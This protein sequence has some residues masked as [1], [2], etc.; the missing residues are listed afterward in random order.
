MWDCY[1]DRFKLQEV[2]DNFQM[3]QGGSVTSVNGKVGAVVL[4]AEDVGALP[5]T[6]EA[7]VTSVNTKTGDVVLDAGDIAYESSTV[8]VEL[9]TI[10]SALS[11]LQSVTEIIDTASGAIASFPDGSGLP[12]RSLVAQI[13]PVQDLHGQS[14]PYPAGGGKNKFSYANI[15][16]KNIYRAN[17]QQMGTDPNAFYLAGAAGT[18]DNMQ[19]S[20]SSWAYVC[21]WIGYQTTA[22]TTLTV[23]C[24][25]KNYS[26][27][28]NGYIRIRYGD[29]QARESSTAAVTTFFNDVGQYQ[30]TATATIPSGKY[31]GL[32]F[33]PAAK[34]SEFT[35]T[36]YT[37]VT[38]YQLEI[39][40]T[41]TTFAP[42]SN[43]C[44]ISGHTGLSV[45]VR[46]KNLANFVNGK[47]IATTGAV[48][49]N[50]K[51]IATVDPISVVSGKSY[52]FSFRG[53]RPVVGAYAVWAGETLVRR[54]INIASGTVLNT[55]D[56]DRFYVSVYDAAETSS[57]VA[58]TVEEAQGQV[59][60]GSSA[61]AYE[62]YTSTTTTVSW[63]DTAGT[64]YNGTA[65][66][67]GDGTW[68]VVADYAIAEY[69]GSSDEAWEVLGNYRIRIL[70][71]RPGKTLT[72]CYSNYMKWIQTIIPDYLTAGSFMVGNYLNAYAPYGD[73]TATSTWKTYL[74][75]NNLQIVYPLATP[76]TYTVTTSELISTLLGQN[77]VW[78]DANGDTTVTYQASIKGY[79][80][81]VLGS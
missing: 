76:L 45:E 75:E 78:H 61:S 74:S 19:L 28:C 53:D 72:Q 23:S 33:S 26:A 43:I 81:K 49:D 66:Y 65:T 46:G 70:L 13:N 14:S 68:T 21:A 51:R 58:V 60:F 63:Q 18:A 17:V 54:V 42:Y 37:E 52:V 64:V 22:E 59:E 79:I 34:G 8:E 5:D 2:G 36:Q 57:T 56:G 80:D 31:V 29:T 30:V 71:P 40:S 20:V 4:T 15:S 16:V 69:D 7:P 32:E 48:V 9:G 41:A 25:V 55:A 38:E 77:N 10:N 12:M 6:Y 47:G 73:T 1:K 67:N 50:A 24:K 3:L 11:S 27:D 39:G 35:L 62:P 44:P